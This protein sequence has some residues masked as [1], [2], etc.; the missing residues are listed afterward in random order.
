MIVCIDTQILFWAIE[1]RGT[2]DQQ[3]LRDAADFVKW[4]DER[5]THIIVPSIVVGEMLVAVD[6]VH[7]NKTINQF[8]QDWLVVDY[9]VRA[10]MIFARIRRSHAFEKRRLTLRDLEQATRV[11]VIADAMIIATAVANAADI[12]YTYDNP[13]CNLAQGWIEAK[14]FTEET[15]PRSLL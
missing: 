14:N 9:D 15:F 6:E 13:L 12:I 4:I 10:A 5:A 1:G 2:D 8:T 7:V 3:L 11:E